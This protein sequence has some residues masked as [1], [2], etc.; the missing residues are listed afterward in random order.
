M[1]TK[2]VSQKFLSDWSMW[3]AI[4]VDTLV[5]VVLLTWVIMPRLTKLF[6]G[7]LIPPR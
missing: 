5:V 1:V 6:Q 3:W 2:L 4:G 7:W